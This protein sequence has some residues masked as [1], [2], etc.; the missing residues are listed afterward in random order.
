MRSVRHLLDRFSAAGRPRGISV[1]VH[2]KISVDIWEALS[3][4]VSM[5]GLR[6]RVG[7]ALRDQ[8]ECSWGN[9]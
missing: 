8:D 4:P 2:F 9:I 7:F 3:W 1:R 6:D 5:P